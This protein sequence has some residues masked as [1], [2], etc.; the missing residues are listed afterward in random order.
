[1][2]DRGDKMRSWKPWID[3]Y[4]VLGVDIDDT[5]KEI[6]KTFKGMI[7]E[8]HPDKLTDM[9]EASRRA[10]EKKF[11]ALSEA[12]TF[13]TKY[14]KEYDLEWRYR[15]RE[16]ERNNRSYQT[17]GPSP[18][19]RQERE[20]EEERRRQEQERAR[21]EQARAE[22]ER[23]D[24]EQAEEEQRRQKQEQTRR[25]REEQARTEKERQRQEERRAEARRAEERRH[26]EARRVEKKRREA[27]RTRQS[28][29]IAA[30]EQERKEKRA[31]TQKIS[32][33]RIVAIC[34]L[35]FLFL[36]FGITGVA[37]A[38]AGDEPRFH[39]LYVLIPA[40]F[41]LYFIYLIIPKRRS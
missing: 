32:I 36:D 12:Y 30:E 24:R 11:Q 14:R 38:I 2:R 28:E 1:M 21:E 5:E 20:G 31:A 22:K 34:I 29:E 13:L 9:S 6:R 16:E 23:K 25:K 37:V 18:N 15:K 40:A 3:Y 7:D 33:G 8:Y 27:E 10:R 39:S 26:S 41:S 35:T 19:E 4:D 17:S